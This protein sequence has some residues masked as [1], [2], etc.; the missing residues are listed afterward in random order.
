MEKIIKI[1]F[2][3]SSIYNILFI[4]FHLMFW[5]L[6]KW[7]TD[8]KKISF[9]N[10]QVMQIFNICLMIFFSIMSITTLFF[11]NEIL[12]TNL[13]IALLIMFSTFWFLRTI[14]QIIFFG[15]K[16]IFSTILIVIFLIGS[17]IYII[18]VY[19]ILKY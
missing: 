2:N 15:F 3:L 14:Q 5:K 8:L 7:N 10:K 6:F 11:Q 13:G 9:I 17:I 12:N 16:K 18:P 4:I 19:L 1:F